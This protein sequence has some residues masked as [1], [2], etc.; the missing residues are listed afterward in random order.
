MDEGVLMYKGEYYELSDDFIFSSPSTE[1][2]IVME[3]DANGLT[4][5]ENIKRC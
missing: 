4:E 5:W 1:A 2:V 3:R